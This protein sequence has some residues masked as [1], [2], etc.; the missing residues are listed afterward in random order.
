[1]LIEPRE[2]LTKT[3]C[4]E[5]TGGGVK[6]DPIAECA[7]LA[8]EGLESPAWSSCKG[9]RTMELPSNILAPAQSTWTF[10]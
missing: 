2:N 4:T 10:L 8:S 7:I 1:M 3:E 5:R 6:Q 9:N